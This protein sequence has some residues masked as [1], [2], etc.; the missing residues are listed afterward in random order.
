LG[1]SDQREMTVADTGL[2]RANVQ[3]ALGALDLL[4][5]PEEPG[6]DINV[7]PTQPRTSS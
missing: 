3:L 4:A 2:D 7:L 1:E 5:K 6:I